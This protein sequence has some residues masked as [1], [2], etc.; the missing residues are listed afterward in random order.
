MQSIFGGGVGVLKFGYFWYCITVG[1]GIGSKSIYI[2]IYKRPTGP[3][4]SKKD[5]NTK[6][7]R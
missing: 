3:Y 6:I 1:G 5:V 2:Y 7:W 4:G